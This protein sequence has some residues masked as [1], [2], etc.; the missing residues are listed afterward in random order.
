MMLAKFT[1]LYQLMAA[2]AVV[3]VAFVAVTVVLMASTAGTR[4]DLATLYDDV[5]LP[6]RAALTVEADLRAADLAV[7]RYA[8]AD[9]AGRAALRAELD[10]ATASVEAHMLILL[11]GAR[12]GEVE[13]LHA[14]EDQI[15]EA[16]RG[17]R[18]V[19][20]AADAAVN[21]ATAT[22]DTITHRD[23]GPLLDD[24][25]TRLA[26]AI[27]VD[28]EA[29]AAIYRDSRD[30]VARTRVLAIV[31]AAV[32]G[33]GG[34]GGGIALARGA[35]Q[36]G[37]TADALASQAKALG[38]VSAQMG[39]GADRTAQQANVVSAA[40]EQVSHNVQ[41]VAT[42][43]EQMDASVREI[44][45]SAG[46]ASTVASM[47]VAKT[48]AADDAV[49][50]LGQSSVQI[51]KVI[52]VITSIAA[53]TKLLALNA[54]IEAARAGEAG[55]GFAVVANEVKE[56]AKETAK[57]TDEISGRIAAIQN[58]S[59]GAADAIRAISEIIGQIAEIQATIASAVEEQ[60]A[61]TN[62][63]ARNVS[64]AA[65]GSADIAENISS[66]AEAARSTSLA[67]AATQQSA[68]ELSTSAVFLQGLISPT[69]PGDEAS[70]SMPAGQPPPAGARG[71]QGS[72][73]AAST[74]AGRI[75]A[76]PLPPPTP[77]HAATASFEGGF[78]PDDQRA[79]SAGNG[80]HS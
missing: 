62:E 78:A 24:L 20:A 55:K 41:A 12:D 1:L 17:W 45:Q 64:E 30:S 40:S 6:A 10:R 29:A 61:T 39:A 47:A 56:L 67:S 53:Q 14:I 79:I 26:E 32:V 38:V 73:A 3:V 69:Q 44:A 54:T 59:S 66:V 80:H 42:A 68:G 7:R 58:D 16:Q 35:Q 21:G 15:A 49:A 13:S 34:A 70:A 77:D 65:R 74:A 9:A 72:R 51:G 22:A 36:V 8:A 46:E 52:D 23:P 5:Y 71:P 18:G 75:L 48:G 19:L 2:F 60:T 27:R 76:R 33:V 37:S 50:Q 57:A 43:V 63:I 4:D 28:E 11:D 25:A 31:I